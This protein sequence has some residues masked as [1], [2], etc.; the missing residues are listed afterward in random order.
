MRD[1]KIG[2]KVRCTVRKGVFEIYNF[3]GVN[4]DLMDGMGESFC[5]D[6]RNVSLIDN[7]IICS[8]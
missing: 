3:H 1:F 6:K 7:I 8:K 5:E 2:D 4:I